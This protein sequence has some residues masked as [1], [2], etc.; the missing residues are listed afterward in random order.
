MDA[1]LD[2]IERKYHSLIQEAI[3]EQLLF[4]PLRETRRPIAILVGIE[5]EEDME[6]LLMGCSL[7]LR[8]ILDRSWREIEEGRGIP[9]DEFW[10]RAAARASAKRKTSGKANGKAKKSKQEKKG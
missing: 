1:H 9:H 6:R 10:K 8:A 5:D 3:E 2:A 7:Q 4:E